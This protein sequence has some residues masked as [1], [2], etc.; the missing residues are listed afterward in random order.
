MQSVTFNLHTL[1][2]NSYSVTTKFKSLEKQPLLGSYVLC[3][4]V[5]TYFHEG[6]KMAL[7]GTYDCVH[8]ADK[9]TEAQ[10]ERIVQ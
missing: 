2:S 10:G 7:Q 6:S 4:Q 8:F 3:G 9:Q 1:Y 5:H